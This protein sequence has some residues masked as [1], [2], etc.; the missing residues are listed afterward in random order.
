MKPFG[1]G[2]QN[3]GCALRAASVRS[4][5]ILKSAL[6]ASYGSAG[7]FHPPPSAELRR[8]GALPVGHSF[9]DCGPADGQSLRADTGGGSE[10]PNCRWQVTEAGI[11]TTD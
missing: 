1:P 4:I 2:V 6:T 5:R 10:P 3:L 9:A 8:T 11:V 7:A